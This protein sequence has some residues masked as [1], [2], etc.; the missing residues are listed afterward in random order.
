MAMRTAVVI[1]IHYTQFPPGVPSDT[2]TRAGMAALWY[3]EADAQDLATTL[4]ASGYDVIHLLGRQATRGAITAALRKQTVLA[5]GE[6]LVVDHFSGHGQVDPDNRGIAYLSPVDA[7]P[8]NLGD[9][10][11]ALAELA[12]QHRG[13]RSAPVLLDGCHSGYA[14]GLKGSA[15]PAEWGQEFGHLAQNTFRN[16]RG[17]ITLTVKTVAQDRANRLHVQ[18]P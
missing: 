18:P 2:I 15:I 16:V 11:I 12:Q 14:V 17:R 9:R 3:A 8:Q 1:G 10:G 13:V 4:A 6:G 5:G 7:G